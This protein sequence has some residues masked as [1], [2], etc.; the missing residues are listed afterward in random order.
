MAGISYPWTFKCQGL[1]AIDGANPL[2]MEFFDAV[3]RL[4]SGLV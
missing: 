3:A 2:K 1:S 4:E